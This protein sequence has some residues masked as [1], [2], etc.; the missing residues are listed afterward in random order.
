MLRMLVL[1][2]SV[3]LAVSLPLT[4]ALAAGPTVTP[5]A[6]SSVGIVN[7]NVTPPGLSGTPPGVPPLVSPR[8]NVGITRPNVTPPPIFNTPPPSAPS[9]TPPGSSGTISGPVPPPPL[10]NTPQ[11]TVPLVIPVVTPP[12]A[13]GQGLGTPNDFA[14]LANPGNTSFQPG[15]FNPFNNPHPMLPWG[16][17]QIGGE[18]F[19]QVIRYWENQPQTVYNV[20]FIVPAAQESSTSQPEPQSQVQPGAPSQGALDVRMVREPEPQSVTVPAYWIIETT[21]GYLHMPRWVLQEVGG[22]RY[23]WALVSG[24]FQPR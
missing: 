9:S 22:G 4:V 19:G 16:D 5:T 13:P 20:L 1:A 7:P 24:W 11:P 23:R 21:R 6:P 8:S 15:V 18:R 17:G 10:F 14:T 12:P 2:L 3:A